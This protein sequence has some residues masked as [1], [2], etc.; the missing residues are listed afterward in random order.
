MFC[1]RC[2]REYD[3][4]HRFC[5]Y[6]G[7]ELT[8][9]RRVDLFRYKPTR[10]R[11]T[12][13]GERYEVHGY[14]G[15]GAMARV[16]LAVEIETG[17]PVAIKVLE[18]FAAR[19]E[20]TR[21][22]FVRE[23]QSAA[24]IGHPNIVRVLDAGARSE[25]GAPYLVMEYLFGESLGDWLRRERRMDADL[26]IPVLSQAASGL[27]AAHRAGIIHRDVKPDNIY[28]VG[29][30]GD[31]YAV[32]VLDFG[33]AKIQAADLITATGTAV[34]TLEYMAP[35]QVVSDLP[36]ARTDVYGLGV[37]MFRAFTGELPFPRSEQSELLARQLVTPPPRPSEKRRS[38][39]P[40]LES[41]ILK[42]I[43]KRPD[44]RYPSMEAFLEDLERLAGDR[45][46]PL[47]ADEPLRE[48]SDVYV[49]QGS[50]AR[51]AAI[52]FYR[53]LGMEAPRFD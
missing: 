7:A 3:A 47:S 10:L 27:A 45:D 20:R 51:N 35:E 12:R 41:V 46:G 4:G 21:E 50:F 2:H 31:P 1:A 34:G 30:Q 6:D 38:L 18:E 16:Y 9:G 5:P 22:R 13:L 53:R 28:L 33:L 25:D 29:P 26:A 11:G 24:M 48:P 52:Y 40:L 23:A 8:E 17:Q 19:A 32:K 37:V 39:D 15:K 43:R 36:D 44:N 14:L 42:A 49:P